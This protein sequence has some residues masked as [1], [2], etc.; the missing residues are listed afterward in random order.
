MAKTV[1]HPL[2]GE[3]RILRSPVNLTRTPASVRKAS[4]V[5]G[6]DT[7]DV[8]AEYGFDAAEITSLVDAGVVGRGARVAAGAGGDIV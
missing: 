4:P 8:L 6:A 1:Q 2:H 5:A 3:L 7:E